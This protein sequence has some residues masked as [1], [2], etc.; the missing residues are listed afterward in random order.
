MKQQKVSDIKICVIIPCYKVSAHIIDVII[1]IPDIIDNIYIIDDKCPENSGKIVQENFLDNNNVKV[2]YNSHNLGVGG[3]VKVGYHEAVKDQMQIA[4]KLDGDGQMN[5]LLIPDLIMPILNNH[6]LYTK[7]NRFFKLSYLYSMPKFRLFGNAGL[8][9]IT[10]LSTGHWKIMDP[11]NGF[12]AIRCDVLNYIE[13]NEVSNRYFF[14]TDMLFQLG[15]LGAEVIDIPM[16]S[17]YGDEKSNLS[18]TNSLA[19][20]SVKHIK[21][22]AKRVLISY[23]L[24]D[25]NTGSISL[26]IGTIFTLLVVFGGIP[27]WVNNAENLIHTPTGT[28]IKFLLFSMLGIGGLFGWLFYDSIVEKRCWLSKLIPPLSASINKQI[29]HDN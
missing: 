16:P 24:R 22:F 10:K 17:K 4:I 9:F 6:A 11:T 2:F 7:G 19:S 8:S 27:T 21:L 18:I 12:T 23:F 1:N 3:A 13:L 14:E 26:I 20:F 25:F 5:P 28:I 29:K 15:I